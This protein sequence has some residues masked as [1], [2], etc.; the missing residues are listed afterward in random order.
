[1]TSLTQGR[2]P[3][4]RVPRHAGPEVQKQI[5]IGLVD[6]HGAVAIALRA[7][8]ERTREL[9]LVASAATVDA[10]LVST[11]K[12]PQIVVLDLRLAD[13]SS[14]ANNVERLTQA[15]AQVI[16]YTSGESGYLLRAAT[17][18]GMIGI[19]RKS[20]PLS[21]LTSALLK[22]ACGQPLVDAA[23][24]VSV[25]T[26]PRIAD[27]RLSPNEQRVLSLFADGFTA[28]HVADITGTAV[29]TI[30]DYIRRIRAKYTTAGRPAATKVDLYKRAIEDGFL[31]SPSDR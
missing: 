30:E 12:S 22:A 10:L 28:Q 11:E 20:E 5:R 3:H 15:G 29:S 24:A 16:G 7:A 8:F 21:A 13:G 14:P 31:P 19:V 1:V 6:D 25:S 17:R 27:A 4:R 9:R 26:D 2:A 23:W 18:T